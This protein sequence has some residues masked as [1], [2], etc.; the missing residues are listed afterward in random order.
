[1][2]KIFTIKQQNKF[3]NNDSN[4]HYEAMNYNQFTAIMMEIITI[5]ILIVWCRSYIVV[6]LEVVAMLNHHYYHDSQTIISWPRD[7]STGVYKSSS[8][9]ED[10]MQA[11]ASLQAFA[12]FSG[13]EKH[14]PAD[15]GWCYMPYK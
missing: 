7:G 1:M 2:A 3:K 10:S 6:L 8:S 5:I 13:L 12:I 11:T 15:D 14:R 9:K 4:N